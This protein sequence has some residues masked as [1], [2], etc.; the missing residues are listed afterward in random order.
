[1]NRYVKYAFFGILVIFSFYFT[2]KTAIL[3]RNQDPIMQKIKKVSSQYNYE[4]VNATIEDDYII[5]GM[6]GQR[7]DE[8]K[9]LMQMK[10]NNIFNSL[11]LVSEFV[12]PEISL[13]D[14]ADKIIIGGNPRKQAVA[15]IFDKEAYQI[16]EYL[17]SLNIQA[18]T[19]INQGDFNRDIPF[20]VINNATDN[21]NHVENLLDKY[22]LNKRICLV[23]DNQKKCPKNSKYLV[24]ESITLTNSNLIGAKKDLSS[25]SIIRL[26]S[27]LNLENLDHFLNYVNSKNLK[28]VFLSQL[29]SEK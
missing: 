13:E 5:P 6:Y 1:M 11:F 24:K 23:N 20:E 8:I 4:S 2:E 9:S 18:T 29:I 12:K 25:G 28:I 10:E 7:I 3:V 21:Y 26:D 15:L 19:L 16:Y 14:N 27:S 17:K 22:K